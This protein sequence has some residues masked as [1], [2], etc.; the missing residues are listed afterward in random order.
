MIRGVGGTRVKSESRGGFG[1]RLWGFFLLVIPMS[2]RH[3][4][5]NRPLLFICIIDLHFAAYP[6]SAV[7][8]AVAVL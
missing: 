8:S 3:A 1:P 7:R 4:I 2:R 6:Q 5:V